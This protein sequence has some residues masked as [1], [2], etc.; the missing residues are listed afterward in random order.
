MNTSVKDAF[1]YRAKIY[2][3]GDISAISDK[4][5]INEIIN[6]IL[7][8]SRKKNF[9]NVL[10]IATGTG[11]VLLNLYSR[12]KINHAVGIDISD[13]MISEARKGL[14]ENNIPA[15]LMIRDVNE[16]LPF[17]DESFDLITCR[18]AFHHLGD[19]RKTIKEMNRVLVHGGT[20]AISDV[21][22]FDCDRLDYF[23]NKS[24]EIQDPSHVRFYNASELACC[25]KEAGFTILSKSAWDIHLKMS[26]M[27][28]TTV[29]SKNFK[30]FYS[31]YLNAADY[32]K[33]KFR[34]E[35]VNGDLNFIW[36]S[37]IFV[38]GKN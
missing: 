6:K 4:N 18:L 15:E 9:L 8:N 30:E 5:H 11:M 33:E 2:S 22:S 38:A 16:G 19:I 23:H 34:I 3:R 17:D 27:E 14:K 20:A 36:P 10:D 21:I 31:M 28:K 26:E 12:I 13:N 35:E 32:E 24:A 1:D 7:D 25:F 37:I 29:S